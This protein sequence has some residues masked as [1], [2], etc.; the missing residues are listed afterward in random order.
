[1]LSELTAYGT[2]WLCVVYLIRCIRPLSV[3][4]FWRRTTFTTM[5]QWDWKLLLPN[6]NRTPPPPPRS[7]A[8]WPSM[9]G[10][11]GGWA[12]G[13]ALSQGVLAFEDVQQASVLRIQTD[14]EP[15]VPRI[16]SQDWA[17][18]CTDMASHRL[19]AREASPLCSDALY[20]TPCDATHVASLS[21]GPQ[22]R[23][24][25]VVVISATVVAI[26][27]ALWA[28]TQVCI[29]PR[30]APTGINGH[31]ARACSNRRAYHAACISHVCSNTE[32]HARVCDNT[33][34]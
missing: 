8:H 30:P 6:K 14:T 31:A 4:T 33:D 29:A 11:G 2:V 12:S 23:H 15:H 24:V 16:L 25:A 21:R 27:C 3:C 19:S 9:S 7:H 28:F 20:Y 32:W 1:M 10:W 13:H 17:V 22:P 5:E 34:T 26:V 18:R